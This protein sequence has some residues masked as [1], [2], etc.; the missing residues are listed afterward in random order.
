M[1]NTSFKIENKIIGNKKIFIIAEIGINHGGNFKKCLQMIKAAA[2]AG[3]DSVKIQTN[4]VSESYMKNTDSYKEFKNKN[5]S[6]I[7]LVKIK[8]YSKKLGVIFFSSPGDIKSLIRLAKIKVSAMK[9]SS[10]SATNLPLIK[11]SIKRK[12]PTIISTGFST[13]ADLD[14]LKKFINKFNF[15]KI[16]I[17]KCTANYPADPNDLDLNSINFLKNKFNL[18]VGYSDHTI[19]DLA[20]TIAISCGAKIIEKH[21]TLNKLQKGADHKI[22]LE[23]KEFKKMVQ[24]IR[25]AEKMFGSS[26]Y[27]IIKKIKRKRKFFLRR[28]TAKKE[29]KKGDIY[30]FENIGFMRHK[31]GKLGLEPFHF[32]NLNK[33]KSKVNIKKGQIFTKRHL[34]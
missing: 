5:F 18:V 3:A 29:I 22:S 30:S 13:N 10:G 4:E 12:I 9:I 26:T 33:K 23:P 27:R 14:N 7:Q 34:Q 21:F 17:L 2:D 1:K 11:E 32:F 20:P 15:K 28:V 25:N 16:A 8:K 31:K 19:G 6:D 24:K